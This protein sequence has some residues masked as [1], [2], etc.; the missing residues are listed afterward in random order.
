MEK[1]PCIL[2]VDDDPVNNF[3]NQRLLEDLAIA[4]QLLVA[5]NGQE[6]FALL[7]QHC[8]DTACPAL[9][10]L[11][12]NMP[13]MNGFEFLFSYQQLPLAQK[14]AI[15]IIMLTTSVHAQDVERGRQLHV[16]DFL[17]KPLTKEKVRGM[18]RKHFGWQL[19]E[20]ETEHRN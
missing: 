6:A 10:L 11:D 5:L 13:V 1:L 9:I 12:V 14:E 7:E 2:L 3:L 4:D 16:A 17:R 8:P 15:V 18:L 19:A 20:G